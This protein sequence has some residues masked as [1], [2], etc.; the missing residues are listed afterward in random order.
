MADN[1]EAKQEHIFDKSLIDPR[2]IPDTAKTHESETNRQ[3]AAPGFVPSPT[4]ASASASALASTSAL[5]LAST[6]TPAPA[7]AS[8]RVPFRPYD[9]SWWASFEDDI[10][11]EYT[12]LP[13]SAYKSLDYIIAPGD[14]RDD[15]RYWHMGLQAGIGLGIQTAREAILNE[16]QDH[17]SV[18]GRQIRSDPSDPD[19]Y[20]M[21]ME[22]GQRCQTGFDLRVAN[23]AAN[24]Y[25][26]S[27]NQIADIVV[28]NGL[29]ECLPETGNHMIGTS[30]LFSEEDVARC[31]ANSRVINEALG[32]S[33]DQLQPNFGTADDSRA[34]QPAPLTASFTADGVSIGGVDM[35]QLSGTAA[36]IANAVTYGIGGRGPGM[37]NGQYRPRGPAP[38]PNVSHPTQDASP[39]GCLGDD[40]VE[41]K[42]R[43]KDGD[44]GEDAP[45]D[46]PKAKRRARNAP[47]NSTK[48]SA[49][50]TKGRGVK[51]TSCGA[52]HSSGNTMDSAGVSS[53]HGP[54]IKT[55]GQS[56]MKK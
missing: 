1:K 34:E 42:T 23:R 19:P 9:E 21:R 31:H 5:A 39:S 30:M 36:L 17:N 8:A 46:K 13:Q 53:Q 33:S 52:P 55:A 50:P 44:E 45:N 6:S 2:L 35:T 11:D 27:C 41:V 14:M 40:D 16:M 54:V 48:A 15:E 20:Q 3:A 38:T 51:K 10:D 28:Y 43:H 24:R 49:R 4:P 25:I 12:T 7:P 29:T 56:K 26:R 32:I 18:F 47:R 37:R 22:L